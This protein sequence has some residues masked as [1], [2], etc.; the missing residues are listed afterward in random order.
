[1]WQKGR[2]RQG[3]D[4]LGKGGGGEG[5]NLKFVASRGMTERRGRKGECQDEEGVFTGERT[6]FAGGKEG[7]R[8]HFS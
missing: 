2:G 4:C 5:K 3:L 6:S 8:D 1:M 7:G